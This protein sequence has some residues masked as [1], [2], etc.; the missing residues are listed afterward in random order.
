MN[1]NTSKAQVIAQRYG[2][3]R[4]AAVW[5]SAAFLA[6]GGAVVLLSFWG[7]ILPADS[8]TFAAARSNTSA[9]KNGGKRR[10]NSETSFRS[11]RTTPKPGAN[12][13]WSNSAKPLEKTAIASCRT[14]SGRF[15][16]RRNWRRTIRA[17]T[18]GCLKSNCDRATP[19]KPEN[20]Q[21]S[22]R[23]SI[24]NTRSCPR[25][26]IRCRRRRW[27]PPRI[28]KPRIDTAGGAEKTAAY[29]RE[30]FAADSAVS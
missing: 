16:R 9:A 24:R 2:A 19:V 10:C 22:W 30:Q 12:W 7:S 14:P 13:D 4:Q 11:L 26:G 17:L 8:I 20:T 5:A 1:P 3:N 25:R 21:C 6:L 27:K 18:A 29:C 15:A 28:S 23:N